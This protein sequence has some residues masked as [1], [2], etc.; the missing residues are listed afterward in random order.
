MDDRVVLVLSKPAALAACVGL[1]ATYIAS[2]NVPP[3]NLPRFVLCCAVLC[4]AVLC[5][6]VF[7]VRF[8]DSLFANSRDH[9]RTVL[10]RVIGATLAT[11]AS[12]FIVRALATPSV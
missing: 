2:L 4:C 10:R 6:A 11:A 7:M 12:P 5:C 1:T 3:S 9:P 8:R